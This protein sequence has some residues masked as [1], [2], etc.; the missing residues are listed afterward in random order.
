MQLIST[1]FANNREIPARY[2]GDGQNV[3]PP[4]EWSS[5]PPACQGFALI[6]EGTPSTTSVTADLIPQWR[7][8]CTGTSSRFTP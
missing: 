2:T 8:E 3:S 6:C 1:V 7:E 5:P 4:L